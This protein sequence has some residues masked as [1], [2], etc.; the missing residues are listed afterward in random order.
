MQDSV[1]CSE[2]GLPPSVVTGLTT[3]RLQT[4]GSTALVQLFLPEM[5][6]CAT[7]KNDCAAPE[8]ERTITFL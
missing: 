5:S 6:A 1:R 7:N 8:S 2:S 3:I 4:E